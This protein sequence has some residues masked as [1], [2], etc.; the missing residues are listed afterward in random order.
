MSGSGYNELLN[1]MEY[2]LTEKAK[3]DKIQF[4]SKDKIDVI[5]FASKADEVWSTDNG[6]ET[7]ELL[8]Q[9]KD[10]HP[11]GS[12]ALYTAAINA[13]KLLKEESKEYNTSV[14]LMTDGESNDTNS[15]YNDLKRIVN[16]NKLNIPIFSITF[17]SADEYELEKI[18]ELTNGKVFDGKKDLISAF[19]EV[20]EYN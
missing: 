12:T 5:P 1:A 11:T 16:K 18:A 15:N 19:R 7:D 9:I 20:R 17:G 6:S 14:I 13:L 8:N 4:T 3:N 10:R 2:I